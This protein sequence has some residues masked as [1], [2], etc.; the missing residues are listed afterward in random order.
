MNGDVVIL[1]K[2]ATF[3]TTSPTP[4]HHHQQQIFH[5]FSTSMPFRRSISFAF[6]FLIGFNSIGYYSLLWVAQ[7]EASKQMSER[8]GEFTT[9]LGAHML[10]TLPMNDFTPN[11]ANYEKADGD[12]TYEGV[13]YHMVKKK[14]LNHLLYVLCIKDQKGT[15]LQQ[16][17]D[18]LSGSASGDQSAPSNNATK[19]ATS[20]AKY[21]FSEDYLTGSTA[22]GWERVIAFGGSFVHY[23][24]EIIPDLFRPP[25]A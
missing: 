9:D 22:V 25:L 3:K 2:I 6:L 21:F 15:H 17:M 19:F 5:Y 13:V 4:I 8:L 24:Q 10:L 12:I 16:A 20:V 11:S 23:N 18:D 14:V 1:S 7:R